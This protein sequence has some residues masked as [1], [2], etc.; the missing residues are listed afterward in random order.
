MNHKVLKS[1]LLGA[2]FCPKSCIHPKKVAIEVAANPINMRLPR[3]CNFS[4]FKKLQKKLLE[5]PVNMRLPR[6]YNFLNLLFPYK[7]AIKKKR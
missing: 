2:F 3:G 5:N 1:L 7:R 6:E 4:V